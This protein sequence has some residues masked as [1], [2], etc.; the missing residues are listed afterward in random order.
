MSQACP[1]PAP[2]SPSEAPHGSERPEPASR[3]LLHPP[4]REGRPWARRDPGYVTCSD[5]L[6]RLRDGLR[7]IVRRW[8]VLDPR[9]GASG[10]HGS[11]GAPGFGSRSPGSDHVIAM[12][13]ARSTTTAR[14]W[15]GSDGKVH[16]EAL[17][18]PM[19]VL[20]ELA[21]MAD[22]VA[23]AREMTGPTA[24]DVAVIARWLDGQLDW[25]TRQGGVVEF[26]RVVR[27]LVAQLRPLTGEPR[28]K[29]VGECPNT[30]DEGEHTRE[31][32]APLYAPIKGDEIQ[33]RACGAKWAREL[34]RRLG[35]I[36]QAA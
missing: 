25:I 14:V 36:L 27:D 3:C 13:D 17:R 18:P 31:C 29:R 15:V 1:K 2:G 34:W 19:S 12:R 30:I 16:R 21:D 28:A 24:L 35:Q 9:P 7:E 33:C 5:C 10:E 8:L 6:D 11:R 32:K 23:Q 22:H 20:G 26:A 4:P